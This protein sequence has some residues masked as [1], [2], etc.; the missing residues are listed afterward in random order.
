MEILSLA[1]DAVLVLLITAAV[2][3]VCVKVWA[4]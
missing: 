1:A 4:E 2:Y 3:Y